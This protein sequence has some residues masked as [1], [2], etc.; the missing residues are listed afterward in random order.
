MKNQLGIVAWMELGL[1]AA[2]VLSFALAGAFQMVRGRTDLRR[3]HQT[4]SQSLWGMLLASVLLFAGVTAW[5]LAA[6]PND[7][8][9]VSGV[10]AAP[11]SQTGHRWIALDGPA[12]RRPGYNPSFLY[13]LDSGRSVHARFGLM[14]Q[15]NLF[16]RI[17]TPAGFSADGRRAVWLEHDGPA[18]QS[19]V[20]AFRMDLDHP[21]SKP[22]RTA[23]SFRYPPRSFALSPDGRRMATYEWEGRLTVSSVD[24]SRL[25][26]AARYDSESDFPRLAFTAPDRLRIYEIRLADLGPR[27]MVPVPQASI[28][29]LDLSES[30]PHPRKTGALPTMTGGIR[31]WSL[32]PAGDRILL[33]SADALGLCD[34]VTGMPLARLGSGR[35]RGTFLADGRIAVVEALP[36]GAPELRI[37]PADGRAE[38]RRL[39]FPGT[40][41]LIVADQP[42]PGLLRVV[43]SRPGAPGSLRDLWQVD[44]ERWTVR[45]LG[46][47]RLAELKLPQLARSPVDLE[48]KDGVVWFEPWASRERVALRGPAAP[49]A[50]NPR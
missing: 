9:G 30:S 11:R 14:S 36:G 26:A 45:P 25:L 18:F 37:F 43:T 16:G 33:R 21:G 24:D 31:D 8:L 7:L 15:F 35:A 29:E 4:L 3:A 6:G 42:A 44:L 12:A 28:L 13:D 38:P 1:L 48:G 34:G 2:I 50:S 39:P 47:R 49:A 5:V 40:R 22:V 23:I 32:S 17:D 10:L 41:S 20:T 19:P 27:K 46:V